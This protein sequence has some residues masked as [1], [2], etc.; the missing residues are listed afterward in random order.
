LFIYLFICIEVD[1]EYWE[2]EDVVVTFVTAKIYSI[3]QSF[4]DPSAYPP[5]AARFTTTIHEPLLPL[6]KKFASLIPYPFPM[7]KLKFFINYNTQLHGHETPGE[8]G[9]ESIG[10]YR[11][12]TYHAEPGSVAEHRPRYTREYYIT[13]VKYQHEYI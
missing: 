2:C 1:T 5:I 10:Q 9:M 12:R 13:V 11:Q 8:I 6:F 3:T 7:D 4:S